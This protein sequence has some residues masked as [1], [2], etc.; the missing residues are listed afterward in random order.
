M[1]RLNENTHV[2]GYLYQQTQM[3]VRYF[4]SYS[5]SE[6]APFALENTFK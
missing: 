6:M 2:A 4:Q 1:Q 3:Q 5:N